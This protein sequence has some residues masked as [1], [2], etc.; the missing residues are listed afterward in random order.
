MVFFEGS[1][2]VYNENKDRIEIKEME[3]K[4]NEFIKNTPRRNYRI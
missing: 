3:R 4:K 1:C 2:I